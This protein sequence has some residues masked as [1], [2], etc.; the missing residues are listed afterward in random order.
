MEKSLSPEDE[1]TPQIFGHFIENPTGQDQLSLV[2]SPYSI[3]FSQRWQ[4][5]SLSADFIA[6]YISSFFPRD[7]RDSENC[8]KHA[9]I[10]SSSS[11]VVNEL[12]ENAM[13]YCHYS[14][15]YKITINIQVKDELI[16]IL[17]TNVITELSSLKYQEH[18]KKIIN[19][20]VNKLYINHLE[21]NAEDE[22]NMNLGLGLLTIINNYSAQVGWRFQT[23]QQET[24]PAVFVTIMVQLGV[25]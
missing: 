23:I 12:L 2:F 20:D 25:V 13:K 10:K 4:N 21:K 8:R 6:D 1:A 5:N 18:I 3:P 22:Y 19:S 24:L 14:S 9:V 15:E 7:E 17:V 16:K 11:F